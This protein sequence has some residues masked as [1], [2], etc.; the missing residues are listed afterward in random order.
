MRVV[1]IITS[2]GPGG[3][4]RH[5]E[6]LARQSSSDVTVVCLYD[7]GLVADALEDRG[8]PVRLLGM[9][10]LRKY[11]APLRLARLLRRIHPDVVQIHL[12]AAQ[13][14]GIP[15]A[16]LAGVP[17]IVSTEHSLMDDT[18]EGRPHSR[19]LQGLYRLLER[20]THHT[21]AVSATT[22]E[23]LERWGV[24]RKRIT[25]IE[26]AVDFEAAAFSPDAR[27]A[28]RK[29]LGLDPTNL[30]IGAIGRLEAVKRFD[31]LIDAAA[32]L[33][34]ADASARLLIVGEGSQLAALQLRA[35]DAGVAAQTL[36]VGPRADARR[37]L[38]ALDL[39]VSPSQDETFGI[40]ILEAVA[41]GLPVVYGECPALDGVDPTTFTG[42][43]LAPGAGA[44]EQVSIALA[45]L[46][47]APR[48]A[49]PE[50][51]RLRYDAGAVAAAYDSLHAELLGT[52]RRSVRATRTPIRP[53]LPP[54]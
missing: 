16:R 32:P 2:L 53:S 35:A 41:N 13:L 27:A 9:A 6:Q 17:L 14:W 31:V 45:R 26:N 47:G 51:L 37:L 36:L 39:F 8:I 54:G 23:R 42:A 12:L 34:R 43:R 40:A 24:P 19:R 49:A 20:L 18:I 4:E 11:T 25:V 7:R 29:E 28:A 48:R 21:V 1:H 5:V 33:L 38:S 22:R 15:A 30:V 3:A 50:A 46:A 10:G 44:V 52:G